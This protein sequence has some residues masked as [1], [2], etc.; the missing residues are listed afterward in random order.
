MRIFLLLCLCVQTL[1]DHEIYYKQT[2][3]PITITFN[4]Q[5]YSSIPERIYH[6]RE[7][8]DGKEYGFGNFESPETNEFR[9]HGDVY[10]DETL[11]VGANV[12]LSIWNET[13]CPPLYLNGS[14][15]LD[16]NGTQYTEKSCPSCN[17]TF[18]TGCRQEI[19]LSKYI[20]DTVKQMNLL[21][22][23]LFSA[24]YEEVSQKDYELSEGQELTQEPILMK[25]KI[26]RD[27][28]FTGIVDVG[29]D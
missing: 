11:Y 16:E 13:C 8:R 24:T 19:L 2:K 10:I 3:A 28:E 1:S 25:L 9:V 23:V 22:K 5:N 27:V 7:F 15:W 17:V 12:T 20:E 26:T 18:C 29:E 4:G 21:Y 6:P 14:P